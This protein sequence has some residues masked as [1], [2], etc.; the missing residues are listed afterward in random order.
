MG[1]FVKNRSSGRSPTGTIV[2][3]GDTNNRPLEPVTGLM[4]FNSET[5]IMEYFN[6]TTW[7]TIVNTGIVPLVVD[8]FTGD[9]S[10]VSFNMSQIAPSTVQ[11]LVF[12]GGVYQ[13]PD[14]TYTLS[15]INLI[16]DSA[17]PLN[18]SIAVIHNIGT[19]T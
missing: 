8:K 1:Y 17:P 16:F 18:S 6:G 13:T 4:R 10:T 19:I 9:N 3:T 7:Q 15:G 5:S 12:V 14:D 11:I 2:P